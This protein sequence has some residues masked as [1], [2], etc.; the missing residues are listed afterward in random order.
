M[1]ALRDD[2]A[3]IIPSDIDDPPVREALAT[4]R[5]LRARQSAGENLDGRMGG[6]V[7]A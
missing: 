5:E 2:D 4:L 6:G 1:T 7:P 3:P